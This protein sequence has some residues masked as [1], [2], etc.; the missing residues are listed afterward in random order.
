MS[1]QENPEIVLGEGGVQKIT[2][3]FGLNTENKNKVHMLVQMY[4]SGWGGF[5]QS[6]H[7]DSILDR[8]PTS[9]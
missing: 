3:L 1:Y 9:L 4:M 5:Y 2:V 6:M 7:T 8:R